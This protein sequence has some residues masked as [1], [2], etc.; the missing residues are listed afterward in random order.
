MTIY[1]QHGVRR[2]RIE[3]HEHTLRGARALR[4]KPGP[5]VARVEAGRARVKR[6]CHIARDAR[7]VAGTI[8]RAPTLSNALSPDASAAEL[9]RRCDTTYSTVEMKNS[10]TR[11]IHVGFIMQQARQRNK[12]TK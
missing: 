2:E 4:L 3:N 9:R 8:R 5:V 7:A 1:W 12:S 11:E 6:A 10:K